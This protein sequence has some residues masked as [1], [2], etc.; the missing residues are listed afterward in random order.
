MGHQVVVEAV[1]PCECGS[2]EGTFKRPQTRVAP[3]NFETLIL[4]LFNLSLDIVMIFVFC[5]R[6]FPCVFQE[7]CLVFFFCH[8]E[9]TVDQEAG[10]Y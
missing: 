10:C 1:L 3:G 6:F 9:M 5:K 2:T 8:R 4:T 7:L